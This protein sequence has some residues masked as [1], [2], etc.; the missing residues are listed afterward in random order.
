MTHERR[1]EEGSL[2][3]LGKYANSL[4]PLFNFNCLEA[5][6]RKLERPVKLL[7]I[8]ALSFHKSEVNR[9]NS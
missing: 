3:I 6:A 1:E 2:S 5:S 4:W 8:T 7:T 9:A